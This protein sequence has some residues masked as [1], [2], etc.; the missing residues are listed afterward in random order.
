MES[1]SLYCVPSI[2]IFR[3][4]LQGQFPGAAYPLSLVKCLSLLTNVLQ[5]SHTKEMLLEE[6]DPAIVEH[7][8]NYFYGLEY[9]LTDLDGAPRD[10]KCELLTHAAVY[11]LAD[12]Y[13]IPG[14]KQ[15]ALSAFQKS[16]G[17]WLK[18]W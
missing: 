15:R 14:L 3:S 10:K 4:C 7:M 6:D 13:D 9:N 11:T 18:Q 17:T 12:K 2:F 5:E 16:T 8:V 1:P